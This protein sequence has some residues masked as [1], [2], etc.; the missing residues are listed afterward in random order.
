[1]NALLVTA[2]NALAHFEDPAPKPADVKAGWVAFWIFIALAVA[3]AF[4]GW[5]MVRSLKKSRDT[6]ERGGYDSDRG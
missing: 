2:L 6:E 3:V 4:I 1:M 5:A